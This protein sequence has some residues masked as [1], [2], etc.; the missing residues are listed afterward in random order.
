MAA[1][2]V[3]VVVATGCNVGK[4]DAAAVRCSQRMRR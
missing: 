4:A 3:V 2:V 1:A